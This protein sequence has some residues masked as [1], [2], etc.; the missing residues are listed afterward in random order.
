M[1]KSE[2][3]QIIKEEIQK[4]LNEEDPL[5]TAFRKKITN[6][7]DVKLDSTQS[8]ILRPKK[9]DITFNTQRYF[10]KTLVDGKKI[11]RLETEKLLKRL[12]GIEDI[13]LT[14]M[15]DAKLQDVKKVLANKK[16]D[17]NWSDDFDTR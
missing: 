11:E 6:D 16:I 4:V 14:R 7:G 2:L 15:E 12:S 13:D 17:L 5:Q 1:K 10:Y 9:I 8:N 3:Q